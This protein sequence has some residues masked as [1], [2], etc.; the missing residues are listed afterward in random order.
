MLGYAEHSQMVL[1]R[2]ELLEQLRGFL[3]ISSLGPLA[4]RTCKN[5]AFDSITQFR[6]ALSV[7]TR[8][9]EPPIIPRVQS[10]G[11]FN[12][13]W[14]TLGDKPPL[15][16]AASSASQV[17]EIAQVLV[18]ELRLRFG[19]TAVIENASQV[20]QK[21]A[22]ILGLKPSSTAKEISPESYSLNIGDNIE[23]RAYHPRGLLWGV[24]TFLQSIEIAKQKPVLRRGK[25]VDW[26]SFGWRALL[27]DPARSFLD[28]DF[29]RRTIRVMSAYK[30][31]ILHLHLIDDQAWRF[32]SK[33]FPKLNRPG[34][35]FYTQTELK[36]LV[37][38]AARYGV[39][40]M[41]EL[42]FPGHAMTA[43]QAY[44][45]LDCEGKAR[46]LNEAI[47]CGGKAFTWTF[48]E[49]VIA[50][51]VTVFPA[52]YFHLGADEP[53]AIKRWAT[54]PNCQARMKLKG[55]TST[56]ALY[57]TFV[58]DLNQ[59]VKRH[60]KKL[61]VWN[62]AIQPRV[63]PLPSKDILIDAW[64]DLEKVRPLAQAGYTL[65]NSSRRPLYLSSMG[66]HSG[67]PLETVW[68]WS[69]TTFGADHRQP[70]E[71]G[72]TFENL[73]GRVLGGQASA[74]ATEQSSLQPRLYPRLLAVA[75]RLWSAVDK[76]D[77]ANFQLRLAHHDMRLRQLGVI[78]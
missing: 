17:G 76:T 68:Q 22:V 73:P 38:F 9:D 4:Y 37:T 7:D 43:V 56:A 74:W 31:N 3:L 5:S 16:V 26:P 29:L 72:L 24:Q 14:L 19:I 18:D 40:I 53:F 41:P 45:E 63:E 35:P 60:D 70:V 50:E 23:I 69:A 77:F 30:L 71:A 58:D 6:T 48:M 78:E 34:E 65:I 39:E 67:Y 51:A 10:A 59:L 57:H 66:L 12:E 61:I 42:D 1:S 52:P 64:F 27:L 15:I 21:G 46:P 20:R 55:V 75:E 25:I 32:E 49:Q 47:F 33:V 13:S 2:R 8:A 11:F 62:D 28:L 44:P 36:E 54:C